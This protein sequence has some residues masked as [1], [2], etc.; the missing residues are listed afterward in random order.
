MLEP[1][2]PV[3]FHPSI[4]RWFD[5][6]FASATRVQAESWPYIARGEHALITAPT[7]SGKTLTAF[8]WALSQ[9][10]ERP[11]SGRTRVLYISPLKALN[12][13]IQRNL[14]DP[15]EALS[16]RYDYP[17]VRVA[18]RSGDTSQSERQK[19][20]RNPP[21]ILITTP[22]S[23]GL[24]LTTSKGRMAL[25]HVETL[26]LD[27]IHSLVDNRR[28]TALMVH[29]ERLV[30]IAGEFQR[31]ALSATVHPLEAV[32]HYVGG[33]DPSGQARPVQ[34]IAP[35]GEKAIE[36]RV[37]F[38]EAARTAAEQGIKIWDALTDDFKATIDANASTLFFTNSRRLAEKVT[39][40]I[41]GGEVAPVAYAHHGSLARDVRTE[42]ES[43]LKAGQLKAIVATN[44][45]EMG[46][47]IGHLDEVVMVQS[48]PSVASTLQRIGR[49]GH[50][51]GE[52]S[53]GTLYPTHALDFLEAAVLAE[54]VKLRDLEPLKPLEG[55]LDVLA[56]LI[57]GICATDA[58]PVE[59]VYNLIVRAAPYRDLTRSQFDLVVQ[60]LAGRYS[61]TRIRELKPRLSHD[62]IADT[63]QAAKGALLAFYNS[64]G[65]IPDRGYFQMRHADTGAVLGELDEEFV[66]E[67]TTGDTFTLGTAHWQIQR[68]THNDV[69]VR[70]ARQ[71]S[72][73]PP[74]WRAESFNRSYH[75]SARIAAF[76]AQQDDALGQ[77]S[78]EQIVAAWKRDL[79]F[80]A[81]AAEEL[82]DFL[83]D[84][85]SH[86]GGELPHRHHVLLELVRSGPA[87]YRGP[88]DP[89]QLVLH[90]FWGGRVNRPYALALK[91]A[92]QERY[93]GK[94][95]VHT[96]NNA[97]VVQCKGDIDPH[98]LMT[99]VRG[100]NLTRLLRQSLEASG[101]FGARFREC[102]GRSLLL[103]RQRFNQRLPLW[104]SRM[105]A[106]KLMTQ[107]KALEDFPV[108]L[109]TWRTCLE[110]QFDLPALYEVL[111][112]LEQGATRWSL[113]TTQTPSPFARDLTF[114]QVSRYMYADDTPEN[115]DPSALNGDLISQAVHDPSLRPQI[116]PDI[117]RT[118][119][120]KRQRRFPGYAP[121]SAEDWLEWVKERI[122]IP[123][124]EW[125]EE[126]PSH[127]H[128]V[129]V[130]HRVG[131]ERR[132]WLSHLELI[133]GLIQSGL[134]EAQPDLDP[135]PVTEPRTAW[136]LA[137]EVLSFY[138]PLTRD[139]VHQ[140]LP[141]VPD[142]LLI[143]DDTFVC[144]ALLSGVQTEQWCD[145]ENLEALLRLQRAS[146]RRQFT[147]HA[148]QDLPGYW[149]GLHRLQ[150]HDTDDEVLRACEL[151]RLHNAPVGVWL[152]DLL[153]A[154]IKQFRQN[155]L[156][157]VLASEDLQWLGTGR[158]RMT[159]LYPE[160]T[161]L[162][163]AGGTVSFG[164]LFADQ[165]AGYRFEHIADRHSGSAAE[166]NDAW[167]DAVWEGRLVSDTLQSLREGQQRQFTL[168][169]LST[170]RHRRRR[171][172]PAQRSW[173]GHWRLVPAAEEGDA[174]TRLEDDKD[175]VRLLLDRYGF[176]NRDLVNREGLMQT[177]GEPWRWR[178]AFRA[179]RI[180]ELAG[181][182]S[183]GEFFRGLSTPQF[184]SPAGFSSLLQPFAPRTF[185]VSAMDPIAPTGLGVDWPELPHRRAGNYLVFHDNALA[186]VVEGSGKHLTYLVPAEHEGVD[187]LHAVLHHLLE[188]S[189]RLTLHTINQ[190]S[191]RD[192]TY[193]VALARQFQITQDHKHVFIEK[194]Y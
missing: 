15:I 180:M 116:E 75:Y 81:S 144:G 109:E 166:L 127:P 41:N 33:Y 106:K 14:L 11:A 165:A 133:S 66:W 61:G 36:F 82:H 47:D 23:L 101:F 169:A 49:A 130:E 122:L 179:L 76:L 50:R 121:E 87:G 154:R 186:L 185:W 69:M 110:D 100:D 170:A 84:Q 88:D 152:K 136:Q 171:I 12:N 17:K 92:W 157:E 167:W 172:N 164:A 124:A 150:A 153:A 32:A 24:M 13:D 194:H 148:L 176:V 10:A 134:I 60:M 142:D 168:P 173:P 85:R 184:A 192:S 25:R 94:L 181:E 58:R 67:A 35:P 70:H 55:A 18:T 9:F 112:E 147:A 20:L 48:P 91:A 83:Q 65:T 129:Q 42:V 43:R 54:A 98:A 118:F 114:N 96:D 63:I 21:D 123:A 119:Q 86:C 59:D 193:L 37:R 74:F 5:A 57:I 56:Q 117:A 139:E 39:L 149:A 177:S 156:D 113:V 141:T 34:I 31:V 62:R 104:M 2:A 162:T 191:A 183:A 51:V 138:G 6:T 1:S 95:D 52:V 159:L 78:R 160:E 8:L 126:L 30:D 189:S 93:G 4:Q 46:I 99:L 68:I 128:L 72:T 140:I 131:N 143:A 178:H 64:G 102:A 115:E 16:K 137:R 190:H 40:K 187:D 7:G 28:G 29:V 105:Q 45:L 103:T 107:V 80:C 44:S 27:E 146:R 163:S 97:I 71:G 90:T 155:R 145:A 174:L 132:R 151:L 158:E 135:P 79:G 77:H 125:P 120:Q 38:P 111:D 188:D 53:I 3:Q 182:V 26:I 73:V 161:A 22:E 175:R 108:M 89:Q 19:L